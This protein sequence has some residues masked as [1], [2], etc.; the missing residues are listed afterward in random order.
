MSIRTPETGDKLFVKDGPPLA[1]AVVWEG[2]LS[3]AATGFK[4]AADGMVNTLL[5]GETNN[6]WVFPI[7][8][9]YRQY[10]ELMLKSIIELYHACEG[11]GETFPHIHDLE[12]LW[13]IVKDNCYEIETTEEQLEVDAV[14]KLI[15]EFHNFDKE[16]TAFRYARRV[17]LA[18]F[19]LQNLADVMEGL[20]NHLEG[21]ESMWDDLHRNIQQ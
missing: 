5:A 7:A 12:K 6:F 3:F 2:E 19:N 13:T 17:P 11:T 8:F 16:S 4:S 9:C 10:L 14:D 20:E 15:L 1:Q 18:E 21:L